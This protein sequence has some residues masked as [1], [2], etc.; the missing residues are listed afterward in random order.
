MSQ[1]EAIVLRLPPRLAGRLA[2][3]L[4]QQ[5]R[6]KSKG[7][8]LHRRR[9][10][11]P[12]DSTMSAKSQMASLVEAV[13]GEE[14]APDYDSTDEVAGDLLDLVLG[15]EEDEEEE[16]TAMEEEKPGNELTEEKIDYWRV[17]GKEYVFEFGQEQFHATLVNLPCVI[18][19]QKLTADALQMYKTG[20]VGQALIVHDAPASQPRPS[21]LFSMED[22]VEHTYSHGITPPLQQISHRFNKNTPQ[23]RRKVADGMH[24]EIDDIAQADERM[25]DMK[26]LVLNKNKRHEVLATGAT[27][28]TAAPALIP[29]A[30]GAR[31]NARNSTA[32]GVG[33][34]N[35][36]GTLSSATG[37]T[38]FMHEEII[39]SEPWM[40][41]H[42]DDVIIIEPGADYFL[43]STKAQQRRSRENSRKKM[44]DQNRMGL[45]GSNAGA[46]S[47]TSQLPASFIPTVPNPLEHSS[48]FT[49]QQT[50]MLSGG[51][52]GHQS[53]SYQQPHQQ[54]QHYQRGS[55]QFG[56][57]SPAYGGSPSPHAQSPL[58]ASQHSPSYYG[59]HLQPPQQQ[60]HSPSGMMMLGSPN[61]PLSTPASTTMGSALQDPRIR[62]QELRQLISKAIGELQV[63]TN[64]TLRVKKEASISRMQDELNRLEPSL[65]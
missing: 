46:T 29:S 27:T 4:S 7:P 43:S 20:N 30:G 28:A 17:E 55:P 19:T 36:G 21:E 33:V 10:R 47:T 48:A 54:Q 12:K 61:D 51:G 60:Q 45:Y 38:V 63:L 26:E 52:Y 22:F 2:N 23:A 64:P 49:R 31:R 41:D 11:K 62:V 40:D 18:E 1:E 37:S 8:L 53:P 35:G 13:W 3:Q 42:P 65:L 59:G 9:K 58:Y 32:G 34:A 6:A 50:P 56:Q 25:N 15:E 5:E 57:G 24:L 44:E 39:D 16:G 14:G